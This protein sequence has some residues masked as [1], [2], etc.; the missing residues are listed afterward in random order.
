[1][2]RTAVI[3]LLLAL[4]VVALTFL[5][6]GF[7]PQQV[8]TMFSHPI[9]GGLHTTAS[10]AH[11]SFASAQPPVIARAGVTRTDYAVIAAYLLAM[12]GIGYAASRGVKT[13][14]GLLLGDGKMNHLLVGISLLGTYLSALTMMGL[15]GMAFGAHDWTYIVQ[16]PCLVITG[17]VITGLVLPRYRAAGVISIYQ[18]LE[19]RMHVSVRMLASF[20]FLVFAVGR[21][22]LVLYLPALAFHTFTGFSLPLC[23][24]VSGVVVTAYTA[25]GGL[26]AAVWTDI[27]QVT[28]F[29]AGAFLT[30]AFIFADV[31]ASR[32]LAIGLDFNKFRTLV[33]DPDIRKITTW[34]LILE[35]LFQTI[36]I[37]G[38]QQDMAQLYLSTKSTA[39]AQRSVWMGVLM[40]IPLGF[41]FYF[42][43]T[44]LF[45]FYQVHPD[46]TGALA[47]LK[48]DQIYPY[49]IVHHLP[50][51]ITGL[52]LAAIFAASMSSIDSC[53][54]SASTVC[55]EDFLRRFSRRERPDRFYLRTAQGLILLWGA[56]MILTGLLFMQVQYAQI[57]WGKVMGFCTNGVL[58]LMLLAFLPFRVDWRAAVIAFVVAYGFLFGSVWSGINFLLWPVIG[59]TVCFVLALLLHGLFALAGRSAKR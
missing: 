30:L 11:P 36:R 31:G 55:V 50:A 54:N 27:V 49:F 43:G 3:G 41:L 18:Y 33:L 39:K 51:G 35:T 25:M 15:P 32:F 42:I 46:T 2:I 47:T 28:I 7:S 20:S 13:S 40:Y 14:R 22:G 4:A 5:W 1:M 24:V 12:L 56:L 48:P 29:I 21:L 19:I 10:A 26:K 17:A 16:L 44:A 6:L 57:V 58:G 52:V 23:I 37:Y 8:A 59:N 34:W 38:T 53:M 45:A 9:T